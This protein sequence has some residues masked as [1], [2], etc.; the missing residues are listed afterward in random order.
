MLRQEDVPLGGVRIRKL[1]SGEA[2][3][4]WHTKNG[5]VSAKNNDRLQPQLQK[6]VRDRRPGLYIPSPWIGTNARF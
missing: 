2:E 1:Q 3:V 4:I 6:L 5:I